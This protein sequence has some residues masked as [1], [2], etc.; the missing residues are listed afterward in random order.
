MKRVVTKLFFTFLQPFNY[1]FFT[2]KNKASK[3]NII[4]TSF[5]KFTSLKAE[6][7]E[8]ID[9]WHKLTSFWY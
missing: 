7:A 3:K 1:Q 9:F 8:Q 6:N 4:F 5:N 2:K